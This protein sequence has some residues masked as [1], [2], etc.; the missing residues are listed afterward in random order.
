[1][2]AC[3]QVRPNQMFRWGQR[4]KTLSETI[5]KMLVDVVYKFYSVWRTF[6]NINSYWGRER[7]YRVN[8]R[9]VRD[10]LR[11]FNGMYQKY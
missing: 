10:Y 2:T 9:Y 6:K 7:K 8:R 3:K 1:M 5:A 11:M 4:A